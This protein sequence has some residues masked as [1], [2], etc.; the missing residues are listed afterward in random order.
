MTTLIPDT[1]DPQVFR[2]VMGHYPTGVAVVTGRSTEGE[3]LALVVGTFSSVSLDPPLVS[4]MPMKT[5]RTF[6]K[7]RAC[8]SLCI[9]I[10]G[11]EQQA[12]MLAI[13]QRWENKLDGIEW[14][15]SPS[16]D[17]I[18]RNSI[19]WIDTTISD[20]VEAGDH[21]IVLCAVADLQVTN[22]V[23][24]LLF[25]QGGYGSFAGT[26][27]VS[28]LSHE[29]LPAIHAAHTASGKLKDLAHS[30][31]CEVSVFAA[32]SDDEFATVFSELSA[33]ATRE[34]GLPSRVPL[35][36]P[37]GDSY[38][39]DKS[40]EL[41]ER[42]I[43]KLKKPSD[44]VRELHQRRLTF[45]RE[46]GYLLAFLPEED[47]T[48]YSQMIRATREYKKAS[49]TPLEER[50]LRETIGSTPLDYEPREL[51]DGAVYHVGSMVLP[52]RDPAGQ[53]TMTLRLA[54]LPGGVTGATVRDWVERAKAVIPDIENAGSAETTEN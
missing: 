41:Q 20:V 13:A 33:D 1:F 5:S 28:R 11:G 46:H 37:I 43:S 25:F 6:Q 27:Q 24:P 10:L 22:S 7:L 51:D 54:Q 18:L 53:Y 36:P 17:P 12:E 29:I 26:E 15:P 42:W 39:F 31:G 50:S 47:S 32:I 4:F 2:E 48:A 44:E 23:A 3:I 49:L 35:V 9:N 30:I 14:Y 34:G 45:M 40:A 21:W 8:D 52:V 16:G 38:L 19:A